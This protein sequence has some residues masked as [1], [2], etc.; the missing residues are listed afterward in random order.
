MAGRLSLAVILALLV[1]LQVW[2][3]PRATAAEAFTLDP[4]HGQVGQRVTASGTGWTSDLGPVRVFVSAEESSNPAN[5]VLVV[6]P[7]PNGSF[8]GTFDVPARAPGARR[9]F[10]CQFCED[11][12]DGFPLAYASFR[13]DPPPPELSLTPSSGQV[14]ETVTVSGTGWLPGRGLVSV[15]ADKA[16]SGSP[17]QALITVAPGSDG[18]IAAP[19]L[20]TDLAVRDYRFYAC[21][22]CGNP[23]GYP[24]ADA[25]FTVTPAPQLRPRLA[26]TPSTGEV[27]D[28]VTASGS[29]WTASGPVS[30]YADKS[31]QSRP[32]SELVSVTPSADGVFTTTMVVPDRPPGDYVFFA[33][34][35]CTDVE[36]S[37]STSATFTITVAAPARPRL[38][39]TPD[40]GRQGETVTAAGSGWQPGGGQV[41]LFASETDSTDGTPPLL[42]VEPEEAGSF[43]VPLPLPSTSSGQH[44]LFAC[45]RCGTATALTATAPFTISA[46]VLQPLFQLTPASGAPGDTVTATGSGWLPGRGAVWVFASR[47]DIIEPELALAVVRTD[48]A[49]SFTTP[50]DVPDVPA[51]GR[52]LFACQ[53]C[54]DPRGYPSAVADFTVIAV[55]ATPLLSLQ[56]SAGEPGETVTA[57]GSGWL[58]SGGQVRVF[59][60]R[61][62]ISDPGQALAVVEPGADGRFSVPVTVPDR[63]ADEYTLFACQTCEDP[64]L[65]LVATAALTIEGGSP[66][67]YL[68]IGLLLAG[69]LVIAIGRTVYRHGRGVGGV[70]PPHFEV[71]PGAGLDADLSGD[72]AG[73]LPSLRLVPHDDDL[74]R[75]DELE[76][77]R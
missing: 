59:A 15:F 48:A 64:D 8:S 10:A 32:G 26:L 46:Q 68:L 30:V 35:A 70:Q 11:N 73:S 13:I 36:S 54:G 21:Q 28:E 34:Q 1:G 66:V 47:D 57:H 74:T 25:P 2:G 75:V 55:G 65:A 51:G 19:L 77:R 58:P 44:T 7:A 49:G 41:E 24:S 14:G 31:D 37:L 67:P 4:T 9:F 71:R 40:H 76:V 53:A 69:V 18:D 29:G 50:L 22:D 62:E 56:P 63:D 39:L 45:Q 5:A 61:A 52:Q 16:D 23:K 43:V 3:A 42:T 60:D 38:S 27:G 6:E 33:C 17:D 20:L 72:R 12:P